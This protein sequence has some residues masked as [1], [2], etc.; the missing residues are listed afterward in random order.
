MEESRDLIYLIKAT[1]PIVWNG[2][3]LAHSAYLDFIPLSYA[4]KI[5]KTAANSY[6]W[7]YWYF[8]TLGTL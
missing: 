4:I 1:M 5:Q 6:I 2:L 8:C 7:P 3:D